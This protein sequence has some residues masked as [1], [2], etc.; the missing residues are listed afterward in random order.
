MED[1]D[2]PPDTVPVGKALQP[3]RQLRWEAVQG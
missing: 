3:L 1:T 2:C